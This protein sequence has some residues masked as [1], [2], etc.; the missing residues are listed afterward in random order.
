MGRKFYKK[1]HNWRW[2]RFYNLKNSIVSLDENLEDYYTNDF[3]HYYDN[4]WNSLRDPL[5]DIN[6]IITGHECCLDCY[7]SSIGM[8]TEDDI[9]EYNYHR[10]YENVINPDNTVLNIITGNKSEF[11]FEVNL[12]ELQTSPVSGNDIEKKLKEHINSLNALEFSL[13]FNVKRIRKAIG[14]FSNI[15]II[16]NSIGSEHGEFI[17]KWACILAPFW[18]RSPK[19]WTKESGVHILNHLFTL[20]ETPNF[21][22][23]QWF[24]NRRNEKEPIPFKWVCWYI[25]LGQGGSLKKAAKLFKWN[26][27]NK[28]QHD[29]MKAPN[30]QYP[31]EACIYAE[32]HRLGGNTQ[33]FMRVM[34]NQG[35]VID[36]TENTYDE[37]YIKFWKSTVLWLVKNRDAINDGESSLVVNW[38]IHKYTE[39][40]RNENNVCFNWKGRKVGN[41]LTQSLAYAESITMTSWVGYEWKKHD[42]DWT[43]TDKNKDNWDFIELINGKQLFEEGMYMSHCVSSYSG[44]CASG[45]SAIFSLKKNNNRVITIEINPRSFVL[46]QSLGKSNRRPNNEEI[47]IIKLWMK[48]II[49]N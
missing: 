10:L 31:M 36:P 26:I 18:L 11:S 43:Y 17:A 49:E 42:W 7:Y 35:L 4:H 37:S 45:A 1:P 34:Y 44:R 39:G 16:K 28:F 13:D 30:T 3:S 41:V 23:Q 25:I 40:T 21:L 15:E 6:Q 22:L 33:D 38:A 29:L 46:V 9:C 20:Y 2:Q 24:V 14:D 8:A 48:T 5:A 32:V 27:P 19:T 47:E 12:Q